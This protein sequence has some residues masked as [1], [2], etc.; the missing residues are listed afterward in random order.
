MNYSQ[1]KEKWHKNVGFYTVFC[2]LANVINTLSTI[3]KLK[4]LITIEAM[5]D[6]R[7]KSDKIRLYLCLCW[8]SEDAKHTS[9]KCH[10]EKQ[11]VLF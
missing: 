10:I 2:C 9:E 11:D 5:R 4:L 7:K 6:E 3:C 1:K 8:F